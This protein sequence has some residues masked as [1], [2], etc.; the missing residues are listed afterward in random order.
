M[1][2]LLLHTILSSLLSFQ[3]Q[4]HQQQQWR[5]RLTVA[6]LSFVSANEVHVDIKFPKL[7]LACVSSIISSFP[8]FPLFFFFFLSISCYQL[9]FSS[10]RSASVFIGPHKETREG[11]W[12]RRESVDVKREDVV[13]DSGEAE[14]RD[15][16]V[17]KR[18]EGERDWMGKERK[19]RSWKYRMVAK[20]SRSQEPSPGQRE[21]EKQ[22]WRRMKTRER[23]LASS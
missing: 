10:P 19:G 3:R 17:T 9:L 21:D 11:K 4:R 8:Y 6:T 16:R 18:A 13:E 12:Y 2:S 20:P 23:E 15:W 14:A 5:Q 1:A 7:A 22:G